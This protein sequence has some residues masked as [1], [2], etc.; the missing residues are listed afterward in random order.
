MKRHNIGLTI[1][2]GFL[3]LC[4]SVMLPATAVA[5]GYIGLDG[6]FIGIQKADSA[7]SREEIN[8]MGLRARVGLPLSHSLDLEAHL[9]FGHHEAADGSDELETGFVG[10]YVKAYVPIG[11]RSA[12]YGLAGA[13]SVEITRFL[14]DRGG[15]A[16]GA[17]SNAVGVSEDRNGFSFGVGLETQLTQRLDLTADWMR[18]ASEEDRF[19]GVTA[20]NVGLKLYF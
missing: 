9:G 11:Q 14:D 3:A 7:N 12:L 5:G 13:S 4:L 20:V 8:P 18:Y 6:S 15:S 10:L 17:R 2:P 1:L 19:E 16:S